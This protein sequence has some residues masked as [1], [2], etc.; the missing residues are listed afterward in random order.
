MKS[1]V[2]HAAALV[3]D[4][5]TKLEVVDARAN[6]LV[7]LKSALHHLVVHVAA[8]LHGIGGR[9]QQAVKFTVWQGRS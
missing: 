9:T 2:G 3:V 6:G 5:Q 4:E 1:R 8:V 7:D